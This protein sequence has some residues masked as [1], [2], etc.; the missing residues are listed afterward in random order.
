MALLAHCRSVL[1][2]ITGACNQ[3]MILTRS[4]LELIVRGWRF[5]ANGFAHL[6]FHTESMRQC[7][8]TGPAG[9]SGATG[10]AVMSFVCCT[11]S[12]WRLSEYRVAAALETCG[13]LGQAGRLSTRIHLS[14]RNITNAK[15]CRT[16]ASVLQPFVPPPP[17]SA[18]MRGLGAARKARPRPRM[19]SLANVL[20]RERCETTTSHFQKPKPL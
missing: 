2:L 14:Y 3:G 10:N 20:V 18:L 16:R 15:C 19:A 17:I 13:S 4:A 7:T 8:W 12:H 6:R 9:W 11:V 5:T 1:F